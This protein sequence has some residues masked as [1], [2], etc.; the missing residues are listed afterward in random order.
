L[1]SV[2]EEL[3]VA[4]AEAST[5][6]PLKQNNIA[7]EEVVV[8]WSYKGL[9]CGKKDRVR[10]IPSAQRGI[11]RY[12]RGKSEADRTGRDLYNNFQ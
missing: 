10:V 8:S 9:S 4:K 7:P 11:R 12:S 2:D 3:G 6:T 5:K 1:D